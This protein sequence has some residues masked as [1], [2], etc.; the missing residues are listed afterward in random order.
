MKQVL[1]REMAEYDLRDLLGEDYCDTLCD[2]LYKKSSVIKKNLGLRVEPISIRRV[3]GKRNI[4]FSLIAGVLSLKHVEIEIMPKFYNEDDLWRENLFTMIF[5][6]NNGRIEAQKSNNMKYT[7]RNMYDHI[8]RLYADEL[9]YALRKEPIQIYKSTEDNSRFLRGRILITEEVRHVLASPG[10]VWYERDA[11]DYENEYNYILKWCAD[12]LLNHC[13]NRMIKNRLRIAGERIQ[14]TV[15]YYDIP[16]MSKLPP[17]YSHY[18]K[19]IE[20]ANNVALGTSMRHSK[21]G[22]VGYG[23]VVAMEVVY[24]KFIERILNSLC[25]F[26][27]ELKSQAQVSFPFAVSYGGK[28][29]TYYTIPDNRLLMQGKA[30]LLVDAKY[31]DNFKSGTRKKP[32][33]SD[34]YQL[35]SSLVAHKCTKGILLSPCDIDEKEEIQYWCIDNNGKT[36]VICSLCINLRNISTKKAIDELRVRLLKYIDEVISFSANKDVLNGN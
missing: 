34:V 23:Y 5:W 20:I 6:A 12:F 2:E 24:E 11:L 13:K 16:L 7:G 15:N 26:R 27:N 35:F 22:S 30:E 14:K 29:P 10:I 17:Q 36:Y 9:E 1:V 3:N 33:N 31:K 18:A 21:M 8:G 25:E 28:M 32:V 4:K 19:A